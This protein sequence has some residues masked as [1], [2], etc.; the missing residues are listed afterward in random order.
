M[1]SL[2][3]DGVVKSRDDLDRAR[4]QSL[5]DIPRRSAARMPSKIAIVDGDTTL[6]FAEFDQAIDRACGALAALG[7]RAGDRLA[8]IAANCWEFPVLSFATARLGVVFVPLNYRLSESD[9]AYI[10]EHSR[11]SAIV[12]GSAFVGLVEGAV[13][14]I[15]FERPTLAVIGVPVPRSGWVAVSDWIRSEASI[16]SPAVL[17]DD[18]AIRIMYTSGTES[19]PKGVLHG[20]RSLMWQYMSCAVSGG[21]TSDDVEIHSMPLYHCAQLDN[22][23]STDL[24]LGATSIILNAPEPETILRNIE[25]YRATKLFLP[26]TVWIALLRHPTFDD[27]DLTSLRKGYYGASAMP[28]EV[29]REMGERLPNVRFWN[30]YGQTE[31][32]SLATALGPD[33]Q[34]SHRGSAGRAVLNVETRVV[35]ENDEPVQAGSV[36]EIVHRSPQITLGYYRDVDATR[37]AYRNGWFHS[38]DLGVFDEEGFLYV[39]DRKKDMVKTGGENVSSREVEEVLYEL[40]SVEEVA[41]FGVPHPHWV[42]AVAAAVVA[43]AGE[44]IDV[45]QLISYARG[46]LAGFKVPKYIV[47]VD[48]LPKTPSGKV[49]KRELRSRHASLANEQAELGASPAVASTSAPARGET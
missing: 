14:Q 44:T 32:G 17:A 36:G 39:V 25:R 49:L 12:A 28:A 6:T 4:Q 13:G 2:S 5:S 29:L 20:S 47:V 27:H 45:P 35:D 21:M 15:T 8:I 23:L 42:E 7:L 31:L 26:P 9:I 19:R 40:A 1:S 48:S 16:P 3:M 33:D 37:R 11:P 22:F 24:F 43:R 46:R 10:L 41:V 18:D 30:F 38:G 34:I